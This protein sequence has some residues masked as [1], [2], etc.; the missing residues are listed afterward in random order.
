MMNEPGDD[1]LRARFHDLSEGDRA[2]APPFQTLL[3]RAEA[4]A[5]SAPN[6]FRRATV[7]V[8]A[9]AVVLAAGGLLRL[10]GDGGR[11]RPVVDATTSISE[12]T[13]PTASLLRAPI[14]DL[15]APPS[16]L[17]STLDGVIRA[18]VIRKGDS[19]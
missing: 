13:S 8:A 6:S 17:S 11:R 9:A 3:E 19:R 18:P 4:Q 1:E 10:A 16:I 15:L 7:W 2:S 14:T 12:W 5:R